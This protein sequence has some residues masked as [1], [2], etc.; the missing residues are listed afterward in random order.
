MPERSIKDMF[1]GGKYH[2]SEK[3]NAGTDEISEPVAMEW[4]SKN[5][6]ALREELTKNELY[7][8]NLGFD[9]YT[10]CSLAF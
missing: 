9:A 2:P 8:K 3:E 10:I 1:E 4:E 7:L 5:E 6:A